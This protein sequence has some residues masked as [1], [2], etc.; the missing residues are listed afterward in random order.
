M[1]T[2]ARASNLK[3]NID[4]KWLEKVY[5]KLNPILEAGAK[6][7]ME[8]ARAKAPYD[9]K[10]RRAS[11]QRK[12]T[13][14]F[15]QVHHRDSIYM[16]QVDEKKRREK[17]AEV[18]VFF[19]TKPGSLKSYF[20]RS[21]SGR[22]WWLERG[23]KGLSAGMASTGS[24]YLS[25]I[26]KETTKK[27]RARAARLIMRQMKQIAAGKHPHYATPKQPHFLPASRAA[28]RKIKAQ[29]SHLI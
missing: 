12:K 10:S 27:G 17:A 15:P 6:Q 5:D 29:V 16:G 3:L 26:D 28:I 9:P 11:G 23:T 20:V 2:R 8:A 25:L 24:N 4:P 21:R 19:D 13:D 22:G 7:L 18:K 1:A 14:N